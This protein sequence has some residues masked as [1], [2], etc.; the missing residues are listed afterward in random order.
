MNPSPGGK[1]AGV[2]G[3][4]IPD[5]AGLE[6][7]ER[8]ESENEQHLVRRAVA[9]LPPRE[10]AAIE[11]HFF[12]EKPYREVGALLRVSGSRACEIVQRGV[13]LLREQLCAMSDPTERMVG[14]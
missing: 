4:R 6:F 8:V 11:A 7:T 10:R 14:V 2:L 9:T 13:G 12:E 1:S 3:D 5:P